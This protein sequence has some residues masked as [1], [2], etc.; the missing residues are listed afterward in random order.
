MLAG[1]GVIPEDWVGTM[2][3]RFARGMFASAPPTI[4]GVVAIASDPEGV[5]ECER[6]AK[7]MA[8]RLVAWGVGKAPRVVW[9]VDEPLQWVRQARPDENFLRTES[10]LPGGDV[11]HEL[12]SGI[13]YAVPVPSVSSVRRGVV[14]SSASQWLLDN[15]ADQP[16]TK[17][18]A[19]LI[20]AWTAW[21][22]AL[23]ENRAIKLTVAGAVEG[24][25]AVRTV[26]VRELP[27]P[28]EPLFMILERGYILIELTR[29]S[30]QL[31]AEA[32]LTRSAPA[33]VVGP[34][35]ES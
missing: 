27:D 24:S 29:R 8:N 35:I 22:R 11:M 30:V 9:H 18:I 15:C 1:R 32:D 33:P 3:R 28:F 16:W 31:Y 13:G 23:D 2:A 6:L 5:L 14:R 17:A 19:N 26:S 12:L 25:W 34:I 4:T 20:D 21:E 7:E 10:A